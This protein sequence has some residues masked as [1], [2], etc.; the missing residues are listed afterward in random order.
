[1]SKRW[2]CHA[3]CV[4]MA[5]VAPERRSDSQITT[6]RIIAVVA[7]PPEVPPGGMLHLR[8]LV[9]SPDPSATP[10][11]S[12]SF[13]RTP[14]APSD[15]TSASVACAEQAEQPI[16]GNLSEVDAIVPRDACK[17]FGSETP[18]GTAPNRAD[19]TGGYYQ[20]VRVALADGGV[21][22]LRQRIRCAL[23]NAPLS[24]AR[25]YTE[26]YISNRAPGISTV[27]LF[28]DEL[29]V[30]PSAVP[31]GVALRVRVELA[32]GASESYLFYEPHSGVLETKQELLTTSWFASDAKFSKA[33]VPATGP[34]AENALEVAGDATGA[35][36]WI[37]L[38][39]DR[40]GST[41]ATLLLRQR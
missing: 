38:R 21:A 24:A 4:L 41:V 31:Q 15:D 29:E 10:A 2:I 25:S 37:V 7:T 8:A 26:D 23:P 16:D 19:S 3:T 14:R 6:P 32:E 11:L 20:P 30:D 27:R 13:C 9:A 35:A 1:M 22:V 28:A 17:V 40:G 39:D 5:C 34:A 33:S 12:W 18:A 36:L